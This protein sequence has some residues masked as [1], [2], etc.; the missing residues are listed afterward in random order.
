MDLGEFVLTVASHVLMDRDR[1]E[2]LADEI[3]PHLAIYTGSEMMATGNM[4]DNFKPLEFAKQ[5]YPKETV[6]GPPKEATTTKK[7]YDKERAK[8][9]KRFNLSN[10]E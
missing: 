6:W 8:L 10:Q 3:L 1:I 5:I 2:W 9:E 4:K 7:D